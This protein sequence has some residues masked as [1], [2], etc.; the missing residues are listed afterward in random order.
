MKYNRRKIKNMLDRYSIYSYLKSFSDISDIML[1]T[2]QLN[3]LGIILFQGHKNKLCINDLRNYLKPQRHSSL[4]R[5]VGS[6]K[7]KGLINKEKNNERGKGNFVYIS[8]SDKGKKYLE[9][10]YTRFNRQSNG[11]N[12]NTPMEEDVI[13]ILDKGHKERR[14]D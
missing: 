6:L 2:K 12:F 8:L 13:H 10:L 11:K 9:R 1:T 7:A 5:L 14:I 3:V 4:S